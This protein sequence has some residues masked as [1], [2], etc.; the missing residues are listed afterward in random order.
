M[1]PEE[2]I[3]WINSKQDHWTDGYN[4]IDC[5]TTLIAQRD[6]A[7]KALGEIG[8]LK[9]RVWESRNHLLDAI[10]SILDTYYGR[11]K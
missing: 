10:E 8:E 4:P 7:E 5:V 2:L 6:K 11:T 3:S 1:T 9:S